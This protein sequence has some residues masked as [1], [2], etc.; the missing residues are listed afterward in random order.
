MEG[1]K[2]EEKWVGEEEKNKKLGKKWRVP[3]YPEWVLGEE[4]NKIKKKKRGCDGGSV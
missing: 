4:V 2:L 3:D 1:K